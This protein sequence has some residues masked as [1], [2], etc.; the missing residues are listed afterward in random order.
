MSTKTL[1]DRPESPPPPDE[2]GFFP[3]IPDQGPFAVE[4]NAPLEPEPRPQVTNE[5]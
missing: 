4:L 3:Q 1:S 2:Q 5:P